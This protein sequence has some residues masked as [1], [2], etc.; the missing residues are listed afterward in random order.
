MPVNPVPSEKAHQHAF[1]R[2]TAKA[3][4]LTPPLEDEPRARAR[5]HRRSTNTSKPRRRTCACAKRS[6]TKTSANALSQRRHGEV[7]NRLGSSGRHVPTLIQSDKAASSSSN[8]LAPR[9]H[10]FRETF[11]AG[12]TSA[13]CPFWRSNRGVH[14]P[15]RAARPSTKTPIFVMLTQLPGGRRRAGAES[16]HLQ[17]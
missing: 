15:K 8:H 6:S 10:P 14:P 7:A 17:C 9:L 1:A 12:C 2:A 4:Q 3:S 16:K 5:I 13:A 11:G